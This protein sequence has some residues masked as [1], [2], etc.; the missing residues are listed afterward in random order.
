V[1]ESRAARLIDDKEKVGPIDSNLIRKIQ[2]HVPST[3]YRRNFLRLPELRI[4]LFIG[5]TNEK[6]VGPTRDAQ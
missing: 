5:E 1:I 4:T 3:R 2:Q 6:S